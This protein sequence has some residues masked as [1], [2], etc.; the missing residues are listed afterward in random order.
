M[1][2]GLF[3]DA[4]SLR[5]L[6]MFHRLL[7]A[8]V[9]V[10]AMAT[11]AMGQV[12]NLP[13]QQGRLETCPTAVVLIADGAGDYRGL[14]T[15]VGRAVAEAELPLTVESLGW[16]HGYRRSFTDQ[17]DCRHARREGER[18]ASA[19]LAHRAACP[20]RPVY[21]L[22]HSAG[23]AVTLA[24]ARCLPPDSVERIIFLAPTV[25]AFAD[26]RP[27]LACS[28]QGVD[29]FTS[30]RDRMAWVV[31]FFMIG[32]EGHLLP[33]VAGRVGF[34]EPRATTWEDHL[35]FGKLRQHAWDPS[36]TWTGHDGSHYGIYQPGF[37][38]HVVLPMLG[39]P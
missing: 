32:A 22:S 5:G 31:G 23:A 24:A 33:R 39:P 35:L 26:V 12:S 36:W 6:P 14:S 16:S 28:R 21:L 8:V 20:D 25:S 30:C 27:A 19:V 17:V 3:P 15:A 34:F 4:H 7:A 10:L 38:R 29:V 11:A 2:I 18:L 1:E 9:L 37:L 13:G